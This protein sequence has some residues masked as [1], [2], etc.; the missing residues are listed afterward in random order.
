MLILNESMIFEKKLYQVIDDNL[1][2]NTKENIL[3]EPVYPL[4]PNVLSK[5][6]RSMIEQVNKNEDPFRHLAYNIP[7]S[8]MAYAI[9]DNQPAMLKALLTNR[10][11]TPNTIILN[12]DKTSMVGRPLDLAVDSILRSKHIDNVLYLIQKGAR[13]DHE[14][15]LI[16]RLELKATRSEDPNLSF[17]LLTVSNLLKVLN[18]IYSPE[19]MEKTITSNQISIA[20]EGEKAQVDAVLSSDSTKKLDWEGKNNILNLIESQNQLSLRES[21]FLKEKLGEVLNVSSDLL[22]NTKES[23]YNLLFSGDHEIMKNYPRSTMDG[24]SN[25]I[26]QENW[27]A[28][29]QSVVNAV[30]INNE[31]EFNLSPNV[32]KFLIYQSMED[33]EKINKHAPSEEINYTTD[34]KENVENMNKGLLDELKSDVSIMSGNKIH[35]YNDLL[36]KDPLYNKSEKIIKFE[37]HYNNTES[38]DLSKEIDKDIKEKKGFFKRLFGM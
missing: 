9:V 27:R 26:S 37:K 24:I 35:V 8:L 13:S 17:R 23:D 29:E 25:S 16:K 12:H 32:I 34:L 14:E 5:T 3:I 1:F 6:L 19:Y 2:F 30:L 4:A 36:P 7:N 38:L 10:Y 15:E 22:K 18:G 31:Y 11:V 20:F 33:M 21:K 28:I